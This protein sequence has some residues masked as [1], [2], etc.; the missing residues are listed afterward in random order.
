MTQSIAAID[1]RLVWAGAIS[2]EHGDG[3]VKPWRMPYDQRLL[4]G[5][6]EPEDRMLGRA[7]MP[8]G[9]RISFHTDSRSIT[10][11]LETLA[12]DQAASKEAMTARIDCCCDGKLFGSFPLLD[13]TTF[14]FG[15]LP[16]GEKLIELWLP[17]YRDVRVRSIE[18]D[19]R[20]SIRPYQDTRPKWLVYGSSNTQCR[21]AESPV[22]TWPAIVARQHGLN[23]TNLGYG[24][25][26]HLDSMVARMMSDRPA[27][28]MTMEIGINIYINATLNPRSLRAALMGFIQILREGHSRTPIVVMS[29]I[30][31]DWR[32]TT[33]NPAGYTLA[34]IREDLSAAVAELRAFGDGNVHYVNGLDVFGADLGPLLADQLHPSGEGYRIW[35]QRFADQVMPKFLA[36]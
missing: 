27:D 29:S 26:C 30:Y 14:S 20:A 31:S 2:L 10:G 17:E 18:L 9:V 24:S 6:I 21:G 22:F 3:W 34:G 36:P 33:V 4:F 5:P 1:P 25:E 35:G 12:P 13:G 7:G 19:D 15:G 8:A 16:S 23:L 28:L 11:N 32:E